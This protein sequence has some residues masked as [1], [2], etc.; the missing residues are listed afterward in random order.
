[1]DEYQERESMS[2]PSR[3]KTFTIPEALL[4]RSNSMSTRAVQ[5]S[6]SLHNI[7]VEIWSPQ[8]TWEPRRLAITNEW[9]LVYSVDDTSTPRSRISLMSVLRVGKGS[10][11]ERLETAMREILGGD[12]DATADP[13]ARIMEIVTISTVERRAGEI[14]NFR[15]ATQDSCDTWRD[16]VLSKSEA[17]KNLESRQARTEM[18]QRHYIVRTFYQCNMVQS[19]VAVLILS[20]FIINLLQSE[21]V[22]AKGSRGE[23]VFEGIDLVFTVLFTI[24]LAFNLFGNWF[25]P[26]FSDGW[27][28]FD[29]VI[30][31]SS[32][33]V[34]LFPSVPE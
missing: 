16:L 31:G 3:D 29:L 32:L 15:F 28:V 11:H 25:W 19:A 21:M 7:E 17:R 8:K 27:S 1:M 14:Y 22:P 13:Q 30:V 6:V 2:E 33:S 26:F 5:A 34:L 10:V 4:K 12:R 20:N 18:A 23:R 9:L 24:E